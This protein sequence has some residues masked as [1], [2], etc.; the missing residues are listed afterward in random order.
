VRRALCVAMA[1]VALQLVATPAASGGGATFEFDDDYLVIGETVTGR[2]SVWLGARRTGGL[3]D[4]PFYVYLVPMTARYPEEGLP[5]GARW[6]APITIEPLPGPYA[7]AKVAF[8]VPAVPAGGYTLTVCN[9]PCTVRGVGDLIGGWFSVASSPLEARVQRLQ[10]R[11]QRRVRAV[12]ALRKA[13][14]R[15]ENRTEKSE[16]AVE[17][18][19]GELQREL[20]DVR[21]DLSSV[22][23]TNPEES[24]FNWLGVVGW[25]LVV[26]VAVAA[27]A[28][29]RR[30]RVA[31]PVGPDMEWILPEETI[32]RT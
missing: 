15:A 24:R 32:A 28:R 3:E 19:I 22:P 4:G 8:E 11:L 20:G 25:I 16:S 5:E 10:D 31:P 30:A 29:R 21:A 12:H 1:A 23:R 7:T 27:L 6:L 9:D 26:V 14:N 2:T 13:V 18:K 17:G